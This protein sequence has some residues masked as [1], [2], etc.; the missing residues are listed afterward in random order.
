MAAPWEHIDDKQ[1]HLFRASVELIGRRRSSAILLAA[2]RGACR[3]SGI[4]GCVP[5]L[6]DRMLARRLRELETAGQ[7]RREVT[8]T[9]PVQVTYHLTPSGAE[10]TAALQPLVRWELRWRGEQEAQQ[11]VERSAG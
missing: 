5:G 7:V 9:A 3:F 11:E 2:A 10:L 8:P 6:S 1:C 4:G